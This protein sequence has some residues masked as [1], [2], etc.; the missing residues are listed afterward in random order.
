MPSVRGHLLDELGKVSRKL[1][2][3]FFIALLLGTS[4]PMERS[5][6]TK[7]W[8]I[9]KYY[10]GSNINLYVFQSLVLGKYIY[11]ILAFVLCPWDL[12]PRALHLHNITAHPVPGHDVLHL[13]V[14][15]DHTRARQILGMIIPWMHQGLRAGTDAKQAN[16]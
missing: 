16:A 7:T 1:W 6:K 12:G 11:E 10:V 13:P 14:E 2:G 8:T 5:F 15:E 3:M 4:Q 9:A